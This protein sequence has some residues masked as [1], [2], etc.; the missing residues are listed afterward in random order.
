MKNKKTI[1]LIVV[2]GIIVFLGFSIL[3]KNFFE[4]I[5]DRQLCERAEEMAEEYFSSNEEFIEKYGEILSWENVESD[6]EYD[7]VGEGTFYLVAECETY[8]SILR[9][10]IVGRDG[11]N[12]KIWEYE[13]QNITHKNQ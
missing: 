7:S 13:V 6:I 2:V 1:V 9:L 10:S 4:S 12:E 11:E 3:G 8:E 5:T